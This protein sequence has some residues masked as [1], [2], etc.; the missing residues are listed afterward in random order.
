MAIPHNRPTIG[1]RE[2]RAIAKTIDTGWIGP[3]KSVEKLESEIASTFGLVPKSVVAVSSGT[4]ALQVLLT[5]AHLDNKHVALPAYA[6][7]AIENAIHGSGLIP[8]H[9]D[10]EKNSPLIPSA[11]EL[12]RETGAIIGI[13]TFGHHYRFE[14]ETKA[15]RIA[16]ITHSLGEGH[17]QRDFSGDVAIASLSA[18]KLITSGGQGGVILCKSESLAE[19]LRDLR[20]FDMK[21]DDK[22]RLNYQM[23]DL[24]ASF[25]RMQ[26]SRLPAFLESREKIHQIYESKLASIYSPKE[27]R[28]H[29]RTLIKSKDPVKLIDWLYKNGVTAIRPYERREMVGNL[30]SFPNAAAFTD[31]YVSIPNFPKLTLREALSISK[32]ILKFNETE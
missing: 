9:V 30:E 12:T 28:V 14:T 24:Q 19:E 11:L 1:W 17:K 32:I 22:S 2:K 26:L 3:G 31:Q 27:K 25:G 13:S 5:G 16:D 6:C 7:V 23:T 21:R 8:V 15:L 4:A 20:D 10:S 29:Y 18:T